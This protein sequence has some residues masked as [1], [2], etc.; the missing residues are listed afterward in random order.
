[1]VPIW[2]HSDTFLQT[3]TDQVALELY[4]RKIAPGKRREKAAFF[5]VPKGLRRVQKGNFAFQV[6]TNTA[7][8]II[9]ASNQIQF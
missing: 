8:K 6:D 7:Y 5:S 4:K 2:F 9:T 1:M 3:T